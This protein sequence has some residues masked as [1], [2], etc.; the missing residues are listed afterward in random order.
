MGMSA[1]AVLT[2]ASAMKASLGANESSECRVIGQSM[3]LQGSL[4]KL[5]EMMSSSYH[6]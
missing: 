6:V 2:S 3:R 5:R 1:V 4:I